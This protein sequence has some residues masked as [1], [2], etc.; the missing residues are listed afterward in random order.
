MATVKA[1]VPPGDSWHWA[2]SRACPVALLSIALATLG[3]PLFPPS[4]WMPPDVPDVAFIGALV[5]WDAGWYGEIAQNGYWLK[6][7]TGSSIPTR[8]SCCSR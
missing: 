5:R 2:L 4:S 7:S 1:Q 8:C 6:A 3:S